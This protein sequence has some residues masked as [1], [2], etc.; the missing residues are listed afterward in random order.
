MLLFFKIFRFFYF[1]V[2]SVHFC[3]M[4][5]FGLLD[6]HEQLDAQLPVL[7]QVLANTNSGNILKVHHFYHV[8]DLPKATM[9]HEVYL[10]SHPLLVETLLI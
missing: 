7:S 4:Q 2:S 6:M 10:V 1:Y 8:V 9:L 5:V 3:G